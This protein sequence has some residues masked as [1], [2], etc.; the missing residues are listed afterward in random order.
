MRT[1][2]YKDEAAP[3]SRINHLMGTRLLPSSDDSGNIFSGTL[4]KQGLR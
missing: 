3:W 2:T 4:E 1:I